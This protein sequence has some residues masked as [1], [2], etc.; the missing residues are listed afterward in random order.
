MPAG[1]RSWSRQPQ[2][3]TRRASDGGTA[4]ARNAR[5]G[6]VLALHL[7]DEQHGRLLK[8]VPLIEDAAPSRTRGHVQTHLVH[9]LPGA[10]I[11]RIVQ[12]GAA[13]PL[14]PVCLVEDERV[15]MG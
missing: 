5:E 12:K 11:K 1:S 4:R 8:P 9:P 13:E 2:R 15:D 6:P 14:F 10:P 7:L 3:W